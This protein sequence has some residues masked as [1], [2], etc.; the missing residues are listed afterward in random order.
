[1]SQNPKALHTAGRKTQTLAVSLGALLA[2]AVPAAQA[3]TNPFN[4]NG[5]AAQVGP[6]AVT[7]PAYPGSN[8]DTLGTFSQTV[9]GNTLTYSDSSVFTLIDAPFDVDYPLGTPLLETS[10]ADNNTTGPMQITF[11]QG[12][13][14]FGLNLQDYAYDLETFNLQAYDGTTLIGSYSFGPFDNNSGQDIQNPGKSVFVGAAATGGDVITSV[15]LSSLSVDKASG[16]ETMYSNN[17]FAGPVTFAAPV[18]EPET[19]A[20]MLVGLGALG[21]RTRRGKRQSA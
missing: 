12:V 9:G 4:P 11:S 21:L 18:P 6:G 20:L 14:A 17:F 5:T 13:G 10:D 1:M 3:G 15:I 7:T 8:G 2:L 16:K 19:I